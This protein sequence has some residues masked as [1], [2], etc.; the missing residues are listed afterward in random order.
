M[1]VFKELYITPLFAVMLTIGTYILGGWVRKKTKCVALIPVVFSAVAIG[2]LFLVTDY[3]YEE[4][5]RGGDMISMLLGP[6]TVLLAVPIYKELPRLK[7]NLVPIVLSI[8]VGALSAF[9]SIWAFCYVFDFE[10]EF[11]LSLVPK[12][13]TAPIGIEV[14]LIIEGLV[15]ITVLSII[16]TGITGA[17]ISPFICK[18]AGIHHPVARGLAIGSSSHAI[19]TSR[20]F[21]MGEVEGAFS[22][23]ATGLCGVITVLIVP[24]LLRLLSFF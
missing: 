11:F 13:V 9:V 1:N 17:L 16:V 15:P 23:L 2:L 4:Y 12:S 22:S 21:E 19:G 24:L 3:T 7:E 10:R 5:S 20:A 6:V 8:V 18:I 14:A